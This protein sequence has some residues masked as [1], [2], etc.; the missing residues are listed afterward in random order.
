MGFLSL[1]FCLFVWHGYLHSLLP[2]F[3]LVVAADLVA[4]L[5]RSEPG[6]SIH[7]GEEEEEEEEEED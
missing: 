7:V 2:F 3:S 6:C 1:W 4:G 5:T